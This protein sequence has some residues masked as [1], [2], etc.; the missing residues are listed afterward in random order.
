VV[1]RSD[2]YLAI[3]AQNV[4]P[5]S[6]WAFDKEWPA[7]FL[8]LPLMAHNPNSRCVL[9]SACVDDARALQG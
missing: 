3:L 2:D 7:R 6:P 4:E 1:L 5:K 8:L 9:A